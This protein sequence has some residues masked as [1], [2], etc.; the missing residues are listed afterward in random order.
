[1]SLSLGLALMTIIVMSG[2]MNINEPCMG[3]G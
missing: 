1:M 3:T 2:T